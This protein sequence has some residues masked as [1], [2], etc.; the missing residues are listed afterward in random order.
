MTKLSSFI[1]V[2]YQFHSVHSAYP[3]IRKPVL[4]FEAGTEY[5]TEGFLLELMLH[6]SKKKLKQ[7]VS[8][9]LKAIDLSVHCYFS[10]F[11]VYKSQFRLFNI[12][13]MHTN[14]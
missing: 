12:F 3:F 2:C 1:L 11:V 5:L 4:Q 7:L 13:Y 8:C 9:Q 10:C 6:I 14:R